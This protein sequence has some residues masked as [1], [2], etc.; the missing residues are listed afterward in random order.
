MRRAL[1]PLVLCVSLVACALGGHPYRH[2][3]HDPHHRFDDPER[4]ARTFEDPARAQWQKPER[5]LEAL[6]LQEDDVVADIGSATGYFTVRIATKV[7]RGRVWG[8]DVEPAMVRYLNERARREGLGNLFSILGTPA[9]PLLPEPVDR[10]LVVDTY[11]HIDDR[12][13]YFEGLAGSLAPGGR[14][15]VVD[16]EM[17]ELPVGPP[18]SMKVP[19]EQVQ[20]ELEAAGYVLERAIRGELP[21]QYVLVFRL[22]ANPD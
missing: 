11:H 1:L 20:R 15:V 2:A 13:T 16:F 21:Y 18:D 3:G 17:G 4:W 7:P 8:V 12:T 5:V 22:G 9:D 6:A 14:L 19:P 10:V